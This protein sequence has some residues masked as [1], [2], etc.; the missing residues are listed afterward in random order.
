MITAVMA[1]PNLKV[2]QVHESDG[3]IEDHEIPTLFQKIGQQALS[4]DTS[5]RKVPSSAFTAFGS[6]S[7]KI[8]H[9]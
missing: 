1:L 7:K 3:P 5:P 9:S 8:P 6:P 4:F 2:Y